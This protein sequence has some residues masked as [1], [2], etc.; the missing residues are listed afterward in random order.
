MTS[1]TEEK[2]KHGQRKRRCGVCALTCP[3]GVDFHADE[4]AYCEACE[5]D[6]DR[7]EQAEL[8]AEDSH[9]EHGVYESDCHVCG[10]ATDRLIEQTEQQRDWNHWHPAE[11]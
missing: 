11:E 9:C 5:E 10:A 8:D 7:R 4:N 2:C 1:N 6:A 3:H